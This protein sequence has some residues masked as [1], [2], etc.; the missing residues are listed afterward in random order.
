MASS[1]EL[2]VVCKNCN[3][4]VSPYITECPYCGT[5]LRKRAP[6]IERQGR[7]PQP[8]RRRRVAPSLGPLRTGEIPGI[9]GDELRRPAATIALVAIGC[10]WWIA[11]IP[12]RDDGVR[13]Y[14]D[15]LADWWQVL[16]APFIHASGWYQFAALGAVGVFGWLLERRNGPLVVLLTW[17]LGAS[18]GM[19]AVK[20]VEGADFVVGA[21]GGALALLCAWAVPPLLERRRTRGE[22]DVDLLGPAVIFV[23]LALMPVARWEVSWIATGAG[24]LAGALAGL[25]LARSASER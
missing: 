18:G 24:I 6:K 22:D 1:P 21:S 10:L 3:S 15:P 16:T 14:A 9:R 2:F 19:A 8:K 25:M 4:Q 23:L 13:L 11:L 5:R 17:L 7:E 12:L 20:A